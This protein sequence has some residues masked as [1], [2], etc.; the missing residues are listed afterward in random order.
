MNLFHSLQII[1]LPTLLTVV[2]VYTSS[3]SSTSGYVCSREGCKDYKCKALPN[4]MNGFSLECGTGNP[5]RK[6][7]KKN[8]AKTTLTLSGGHYKGN[9]D[10]EIGEEHNDEGCACCS[11]PVAQ[12][13]AK[14]E[15]I[16]PLL[17]LLII[18]P[19]LPCLLFIIHKITKSKKKKILLS[20]PASFTPD[21]KMSLPPGVD[22]K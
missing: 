5:V 21:D 17:S 16:I 1:L 8:I 9:E 11:T 6:N 3:T 13:P 7:S 18:I 14:K 15:T 20:L 10:E 4:F 19:I 22:F 2:L 12:E